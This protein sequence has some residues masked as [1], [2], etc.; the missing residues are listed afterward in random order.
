MTATANV[1]LNDCWKRIGVTGDHSCP[2]LQELAHCRNCE[3]YAG[4]AAR[5]LQR[6]VDAGYLSDWAAHFRAPAASAS[7]H[8]AS[9]M[10][11]RIGREWLALPTATLLQV[12]Q[13]ATPHRLPHRNATGLRGVVNVGGKLYPCMELAELL[14]IDAR[15]GEQRQGRHTFARLLLVQ[16]EEQAFAI[17]VAD[18]HGIVRYVTAELATPAAT[19]NKGLTR[20]LCGVLAQ[21]ALQV[22]CLDAGLLG[23]QLAKALR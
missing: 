14:G 10:V 6:P 15:E 19:I 3:V 22:G 1:P 12:A 20:Y 18:V 2:K 8:D 11:F 13:H 17:P 9:A 4:A 16:L 23:H 7:R 5:N 21:G